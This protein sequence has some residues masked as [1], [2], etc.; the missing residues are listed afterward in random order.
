MFICFIGP[1]LFRSSDSMFWLSNGE[2]LWVCCS[3]L[4]AAWR[5]RDQQTVIDRVQNARHDQARIPLNH[6]VVFHLQS[7]VLPCVY[8]A[9]LSHLQPRCY[10]MQISSSFTIARNRY[11]GEPWLTFGNATFAGWLRG[12]TCMLDQ[13][14]DQHPF[15]RYPFVH[16]ERWWI[17]GVNLMD[18]TKS[19]QNKNMASRTF[20][21]A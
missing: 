7:R 4:P 14:S 8:K 19:L 3:S 5:E 10:V 21:S 11:M 1:K 15:V 9:G 20:V 12:I 2:V 16:L 6:A 17:W 18:L 13:G